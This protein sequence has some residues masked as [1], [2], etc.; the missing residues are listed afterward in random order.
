MEGVTAQGEEEGRE[1]SAAA[2]G[3]RNSLAILVATVVVPRHRNSQAILVVIAVEQVV[4][5]DRVASRAGTTAH[6]VVTT[7][8]AKL[9]RIVTVETR[10]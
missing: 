3:H 9:D 7:E 5:G 2:P 6:W 10:A 4:L 8:V 1:E